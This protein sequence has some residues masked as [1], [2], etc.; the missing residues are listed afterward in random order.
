MFIAALCMMAKTWK[1]LDVRCRCCLS[2]N[3]GTEQEWGPLVSGRHCFPWASGS[4]GG[5]LVTWKSVYV[6]ITSLFLDSVTRLCTRLSGVS[7]QRA[8]CPGVGELESEY[9]NGWPPSAFFRSFNLFED[10]GSYDQNSN[11]VL[12]KERYLVYH[13]QKCS[14][15]FQGKQT[16]DF[17]TFD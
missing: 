2:E 13:I 11:D 17:T 8:G 1:H 7:C 3:T 10:L 9:T 14:V 12:L 4:A 16:A 15:V 6:F 5:K